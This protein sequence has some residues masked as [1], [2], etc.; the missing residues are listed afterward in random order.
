MPNETGYGHIAF[1][2]VDVAEA[3]N[4][5]LD[6]GG[7]ALGRITRA[8]IAGTGDVE[9]VYARDPEGNVIEL[10]AWH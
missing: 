10:Q 7:R 3:L 8:H 2:V 1:E 9:I 4:A 5:V 6:H